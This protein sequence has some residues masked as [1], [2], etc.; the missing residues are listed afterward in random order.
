MKRVCIFL[1]SGTGMTKYVVNKIRHEFGRKQISVDI[2]YIGD[3]IVQEIPFDVYDAIGIAYPVHAFNAPEIVIRFANELI[4]MEPKR[5]FIVSTAGEDSIINLASSKL[6][7]NILSKNGFDVYYDKQFAMPSNFVV[8]CKEE[9]VKQLLDEVDDKVPNVVNELININFYRQ[10]YNSIAAFLSFVGRMEWFG[11]KCAGKFFY[12]D[13][14][15]SHCGV[16]VDNC[17]N[18]NIIADRKQIC[19]KWKCGLCM[20]CL[21]LCPNHS[22]RV[23]RPLRFICFD[24][25][26]DD[27]ELQDMRKN[28][29][30]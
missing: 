15:C 5:T 27:I 18:H 1:F 21:Y 10:E 29:C 23:R 9:K 8:K 4:K 30:L 25:W 7:I 26:Y 22:I 28:K 17:P 6:L 16:C 2:Y 11:A 19:F 20:R 24:S 12:T 13:D 3:V 14:T